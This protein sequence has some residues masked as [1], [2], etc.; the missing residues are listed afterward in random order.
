M[1][2][3]Y[4]VYVHIFKDGKKYYGMTKNV[5][6]RWRQN[7]YEYKKHRND[8]YNAI[9]EAG[10]D[11]IEHLIIADNLTKEEAKLLEEQLIKDN[12]TYDSNY[13][14]NK[15]IGSKRTEEQKIYCYGNNYGNNYWYGKTGKNHPKFGVSNINPP[16]KAVIC[17]STNKVFDSI[18]DASEYYG[19]NRPNISACCKGKRNHCGKLSDGTK[20]IWRYLTIIEL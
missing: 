6:R 14:Y 17:I 13:G 10:W 7:G 19:I 12:K 1:D 15:Y 20:L 5:K 8:F 16:K 11:N 9:I 18:V 2:N 3:N 4:C